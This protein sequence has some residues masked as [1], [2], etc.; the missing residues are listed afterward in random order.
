MKKKMRV[1]Q[2]SGL[3]GLFLAVFVVVC[4]AAGF[5]AF[6]SI[7]AMK[8]WN[9]AAE[10]LSLPLISAWQGLML[11]AI[12]AISGFIINDKQKYLTAFNAGGKLSEKDI[13]KIMERAKIQ[14]QTRALDGMLLKSEDFKPIEKHEEEKEKE[15]V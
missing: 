15:N 4:L 11:W 9:C 2:I 12:V 3:R 14:A 1:I 5:I 6:P 7:V 10:Y 13:Q 8:L